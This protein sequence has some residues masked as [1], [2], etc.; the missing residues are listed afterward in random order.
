[1]IYFVSTLG[2]FEFNG[3]IIVLKI[4]YLVNIQNYYH[5]N[6]YRFKEF[7]FCYQKVCNVF[8]I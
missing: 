1:M 5:L 6:G 4:I 8:L 3:Y 7:T 2:Y